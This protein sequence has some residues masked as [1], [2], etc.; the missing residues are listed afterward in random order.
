MQPVM[1]STQLE[2]A[3]HNVPQAAKSK[4]VCC[5][6]IETICQ[7]YCGHLPADGLQW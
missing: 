1:L 2:A 5:S 7:R 3:A 6:I 4:A